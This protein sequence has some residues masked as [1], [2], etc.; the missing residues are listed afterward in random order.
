MQWEI[1]LQPLINPIYVVGNRIVALLISPPIYVVEIEGDS[2]IANLLQPYMFLVSQHFI[3]QGGVIF[4]KLLIFFSQL[5]ILLEYK[6]ELSHSWLQERRGNRYKSSRSSHY[7]RTSSQLS[8][9][10]F[11]LSLL[12]FPSSSQLSISPF[13]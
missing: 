1:E 13:H 12:S 9:S 7:L 3:L 8:I 4:P 10:P 6:S 5:S 2:F 11:H